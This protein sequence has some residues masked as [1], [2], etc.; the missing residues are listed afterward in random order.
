M[1]EQLLIL[2][3]T[4]L[5][6]NLILDHMLGVDPL[7]AVSRKTRLAADLSLLMLLVLP[8]TT[9]GTWLLN[10]LILL[11]YKLPH[12]QLIGLV[13]LSSLLVMLVASLTRRFRP[14][15]HARIE[16]YVPLIM[17]N[18]SILGVALLNIGYDQGLIGS[19][20][21]GLGTAAGFGLVLLLVSAIRE[22]VSA[23]DVPLPF[24]GVAILLI[25]LGLMSMAFMGFNGI[26]NIQ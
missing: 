24:K 26:G 19:L 9:A 2:I 5:V 16:L 13:L 17:V 8:V 18:C 25:T 1:S 7:F 11:P 14:A 22:R 6:S 10:S 23:A 12:L 15:L 21:I 20:F 3:S 4:G